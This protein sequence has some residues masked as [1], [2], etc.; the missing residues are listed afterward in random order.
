MRN[1]KGT[2]I[3][4]LAVVL[5]LT[6]EVAIADELQPGDPAPEISG[7]SISHGEISLEGL[8]GKVVLLQF[9]ASWC[10]TCIDG[11]PALK[12]L[13]TDLAGDD[14]EMLGVS[15]DEDM[16]AVRR[17]I[18]IHKI[19]WPQLCDGKGTLSETARAYRVLG[20]PRFVLIDREGNV[21]ASY[22]KP[23]DIENELKAL[24]AAE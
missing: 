4:I 11:M 1:P 17:A 24:L 21:A 10:T 19:S 13:Y 15:L 7:E 9:W 6:A 20:T 12:S 18:A 8:E 22:V 3:G 5:A 2:W 23:A 14:F 16:R